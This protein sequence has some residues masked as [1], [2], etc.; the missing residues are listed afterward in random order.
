M[1]TGLRARTVIQMKG[2]HSGV[3]AEWRTISWLRGCAQ[4]RQH[5]DVI[6][7]TFNLFIHSF[8]HKIRWFQ[9]SPM[10]L[11]C[12]FSINNIFGPWL[13]AEEGKGWEVGSRAL[14]VPSPSCPDTLTPPGAS[15]CGVAR[16]FFTFTPNG[17]VSPWGAS[18]GGWE[19][20][21]WGR[22]PGQR[23]GIPSLLCPAVNGRTA[24]FSR[25]FPRLLLLSYFWGK[26]SQLADE[27]PSCLE[28]WK[29]KNPRVSDAWVEG[30]GQI[31][32]QSFLLF[33]FIKRLMSPTASWSTT[34]Q[35]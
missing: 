13:L 15:E 35:F 26:K 20:G 29:H 25:C 1:N 18:Q 7:D 9:I 16:S 19:G 34:L 31:L 8:I 6:D 3:T 22:A 23:A 30:F 24:L 4:L 12:G 10:P 17:P 27:T 28:T 32:L 2:E 14:D 5:K 11:L 33:S 21:S